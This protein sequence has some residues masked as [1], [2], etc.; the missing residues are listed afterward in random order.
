MNR[1][2]LVGQFGATVAELHPVEAVYL[3]LLV[4]SVV[5]FALM[6]VWVKRGRSTARIRAVVPL[7]NAAI[8]WAGVA[9]LELLATD[10]GLNRWLV[11]LR[12]A[13][14]Y[15]TVVMFVHF[16][17]V[18][19]GRSTSLR[20][21]FNALFVGGIATGVIGLVTNPWLGLHFDPLVFTTDPFPYYRTG[22][23][24][25]WLS[26]FLWSYIGIAAALYYLV[27]LFVTSQH[28]SSRPLV[29]Y[30]VGI[31]LGLVPSAA[32]LTGRV[33]TLPGYDHTV[34]GLSI[35]GAT[36]FVGAWL[37]MVKIAPISRDRLLGTTGDGLIVRDDTGQVVDY[38][39]EATQFLAAPDGNPI[40]SPL[41]S[42]AP[43]LAAALDGTD[44]GA[45]EK[46]DSAAGQTVEFT[47]DDR[48]YSMVVSPITDGGTVAGSALLIRDVTER[49]EN[50]RE[51][52]RQNRQLDEFASSITH[53]LRN[54]LQVASGQTELARQRLA[55][56]DDPPGAVDRDRLDD[57]ERA[58]GRMETIITDLRTLAEQGKSVEATAPVA[59][60]DAARTAWAHVDTGGATLTVVADGIIQADESRL[61]SV[62]ENLIRNSV[63]HGSSTDDSGGVAITVR[64]TEDGFVFE[65]DGPGIDADH[66]RLFEYGYTTSSEG[67][68]LGLSIVETMAE[69]HGWSVR[70]DP[71]GDGARFVV[72]GAVTAPEPDAVEL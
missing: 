12:T 24:P 25:L 68:G 14:S 56:G 4:G 13:C 70:A 33:S 52:R 58:L 40:A 21:P 16:G 31:L 59:F 3:S 43:V 30:T 49:Y 19:S 22:V 45:A 7:H 32:T 44:S 69:S 34:L 65:D 50:R 63:E 38:N 47:H 67:T 71:D 17:T 37:G 2:G 66:D 28:R 6:N 26:G 42:A 15:L 5:T 36:T 39:A 46:S 29:V 64:L 54:P 9:A 35:V 11:Y 61:L 62:L 1:G 60:G 10:Q 20:Q 27:E 8:L 55:D 41:S 72:T 57:L 23:G 53:H 18:Y 48:R 51:L